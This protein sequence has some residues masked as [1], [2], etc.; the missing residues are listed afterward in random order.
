MIN[1]NERMFVCVQADLGSTQIVWNIWPAD[2][3]SHEVSVQH[4][5]NNQCL[6][7]WYNINVGTINEFAQTDGHTDD[8]RDTI[9]PRHY[10]VAGYKKEQLKPADGQELIL[11][12][13]TIQRDR[14]L[15]AFDF[16]FHPLYV[17]IL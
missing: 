3:I 6:T 16:M 14:S 7:N 15:Y 13:F 17:S 4:S 8:Q 1:L 12:W 11:L 9:I 10:C 2:L 5:K